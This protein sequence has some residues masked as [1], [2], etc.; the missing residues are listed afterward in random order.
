MPEAGAQS[1]CLASLIETLP[2]IFPLFPI[3]APQIR[4]AWC[5]LPCGN[6]GN[7]PCLTAQHG[8]GRGGLAPGGTAFVVALRAE[9]MLKIVVGP[10]Q[11]RHG[12]AV[13]QPRTIAAADLAEVLDGLAQAARTVAVTGHGPQQA[14]EAAL[15]RG[16]ILVLMVVQDV[17]RPMD[18]LVGPFDVRPQRGGLFQAMLDQVQQRRKLRWGPPF[19][20]TRSTL[21]ATASNRPLS[22]RP[23]AASGGWPS[24]VMALRTAAQ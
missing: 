24:S 22:F 5:A 2:E 12:V 16:G 7:Q 19:S 14:V 17:R 8:C 15:H 10:R 18:P 4:T 1:A 9:L 23:E 20:I 13:K 6:G 11:I 3:S 21:S